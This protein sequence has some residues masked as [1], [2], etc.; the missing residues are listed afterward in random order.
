MDGSVR[1]V[2]AGETADPLGLLAKVI[3]RGPAAIAGEEVRLELTRLRDLELSV[4][5]A[6]QG[7]E[8]APHSAISR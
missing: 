2:H 1:N 8:A 4:E 6:A 5:I 7:E 3:D